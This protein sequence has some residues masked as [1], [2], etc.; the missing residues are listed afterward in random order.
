MDASPPDERVPKE[1]EGDLEECLD[2]FNS[3]MRSIKNVV[4]ER[5]A[6]LNVIHLNLAS[7]KIISGERQSRHLNQSSE[8]G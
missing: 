6:F 3:T 5:E 1:Q 7:H 2:R 4:R 8:C